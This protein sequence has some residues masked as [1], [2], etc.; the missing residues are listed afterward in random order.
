MFINATKIISII[1]TR[2]RN[3]SQAQYKLGNEIKIQ[4]DKCKYLGDTLSKDLNLGE[5]IN[6]GTGKGWRTFHFVSRILLQST[7]ETKDVT[8]KSIF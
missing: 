7:R 4:V 1:F 2:K 8:Y 6:S 3:V 5:H